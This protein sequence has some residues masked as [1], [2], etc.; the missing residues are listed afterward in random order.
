VVVHE[1]CI[2]LVEKREEREK[3]VEEG[4]H[5]GEGHGACD[6]RPALGSPELASFAGQGWGF[7][8]SPGYEGEGRALLRTSQGSSVASGCDLRKE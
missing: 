6:T 8:A 4:K 2:S 7:F 1:T 3:V 5:G